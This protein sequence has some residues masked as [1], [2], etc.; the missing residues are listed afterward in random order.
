MDLTATFA[1][2]AAGTSNTP[3]Y[4]IFSGRFGEKFIQWLESFD[5][6]QHAYDRME[7]RAA[8]SHGKYFIFSSHTKGA[9]ASIDTS[10]LCRVTRLRQTP[11]LDAT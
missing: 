3:R 5:R 10:M 1:R 9:V 4:H 8:E 11:I 6:L 7:Q 2:D